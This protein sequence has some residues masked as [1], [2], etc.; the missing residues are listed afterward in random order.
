MTDEPQLYL[1]LSVDVI[2]STALKYSQKSRIGDWYNF[3]MDFYVSFPDEFKTNLE[4]EY[5]HEKLKYKLN[6]LIVWKHAGDEILF[7]A[8]ITQK[9]EIPCIVAAFKKT[10]EDWYP[11]KH[12]LDVKGCVWTGQFPFIDRM[13]NGKGNAS[14]DFLGPS[15]DYG[16]RLGKYAAKDEIALSVEVADQINGMSSLQSSLYYLKSEN[17][18]GVFGDKKYP[19]F[20][21]KLDNA[22]TDEYTYLK[23]SCRQTNLDDYIKKYYSDKSKSFKEKVSRIGR[24]IPSYLKGKEELCKKIQ[25]SKTAEQLSAKEIAPKKR[26]DKK[27]FKEYE[28]LVFLTSSKTKKK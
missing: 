23:Y 21:I 27:A 12:K 20:V 26:G 28:G 14:L 2:D 13:V 10:L 6:N 17:L 18:K 19:I 11:S 7:Y 5:R 22:K 1:F 4:A 8:K 15:I 3:I 9:N 24:D 25:M 16:F